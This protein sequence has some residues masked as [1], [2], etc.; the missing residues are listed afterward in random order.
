VA[1]G[2]APGD[3][4]RTAEKKS[5]DDRAPAFQAW[6]KTVRDRGSGKNGGAS[7]TA[8]KA[9]FTQVNFSSCRNWSSRGLI[10][11][12]RARREELPTLL[13]RAERRAGPVPLP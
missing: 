5:G 7:A 8:F 2:A 12:I 4:T 13:D 3:T 11:T 9:M 6:Y 10:H 1:G